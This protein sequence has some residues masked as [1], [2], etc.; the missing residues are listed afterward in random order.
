MD[1][2]LDPLF[3]NNLFSLKGEKWREIRN[4]LTPAFTSSKMKGMHELIVQV[5]QNLID[6]IDHLTSGNSKNVLSTKDLFTKYTNDVMATCAFGWGI[7]SYKEPNNEFYRTVKRYLD[8]EGLLGFKFL[9]ARSFPKLVKFLK[10]R[11]FPDNVTRFF[12]NVVRR[13]IEMRQQKGVTRPDM[14]QLMMEAGGIFFIFFIMYDVSKTKLRNC[15]LVFFL[16]SSIIDRFS[17]T[18]QTIFL[19]S[20]PIF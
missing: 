17:K 6:H 11:L 14:I 13:T 18:N 16:N 2:N 12:E 7:N 15:K 20:E 19:F 1:P 3:A 10:I 4:L 8:L 9:L 5:T